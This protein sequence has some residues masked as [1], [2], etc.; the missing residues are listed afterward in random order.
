MHEAI[1]TNPKNQSQYTYV[2]DQIKKM[3]LTGEL[4]IGDRLPPERDLAQRYNV[5]RNS[6][7]EAMRTLQAIGLLE[8]RQGSG[9]YIANNLKEQLSDSLSLIFMLDHCSMTDLTSLRRTFEAETLRGIVW[10][11]DPAVWKRFENLA[12]RIRISKSI[13]EI[14]ELDVEF[15]M[16]VASLST[17]PLIQYLQ[18]SVN[19]AYRQNVE[20]LNATYPR[21]SINTLEYAQEYQLEIV[22]ALLSKDIPT[23]E[24]ALYRHYSYIRDYDLDIETLYEEYIRKTGSQ[25]NAQNSLPQIAK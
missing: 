22:N 2:I 8:C 13:D 14:E 15:H 3:I 9:N 19:T 24:K 20:F 6:V 1:D 21:W 7:R 11:D 10:K 4:T 18:T 5:S 12:H 25:P 17:N 23:I 16:L